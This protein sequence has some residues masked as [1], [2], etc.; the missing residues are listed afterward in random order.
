VEE[1]QRRKKPFRGPEASCF[2]KEESSS[3]FSKKGL[4]ERGSR[5][6]HYLFHVLGGGAGEGTLREKRK[7]FLLPSKNRLEDSIRGASEGKRGYCPHTSRL[8][9]KKKGGKTA[10]RKKKTSHS[11]KRSLYWGIE[12][13]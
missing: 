2:R 5:T 8:W 13:N 1:G 7:Q 10:T 6:Q 11:D 12:K 3:L 9:K 4:G